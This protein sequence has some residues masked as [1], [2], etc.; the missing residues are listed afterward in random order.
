M[1]F[2][3]GISE[4]VASVAGTNRT[5]LTNGTEEVEFSAVTSYQW[6]GPVDV[7]S[8]TVEDGSNISDHARPQPPAVAISAQIT[9]DD[10]IE[11]FSLFGLTASQ[12]LLKLQVWRLTAERL[13]LVVP[14]RPDFS[15]CVIKDLTISQSQPINAYEIGLTLVFLPISK[16]SERTIAAP[17]STRPVTQGGRQVTQSQTVPGSPNTVN[18]SLARSLY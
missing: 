9:I 7:T 8:Y 14:D 2:T 13:T 4:R 6:S 1:A 15:S 17:Q 18:R 3:S 10:V 12:K 16:S 11:G 5:I